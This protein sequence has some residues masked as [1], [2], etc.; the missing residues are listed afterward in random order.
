MTRG[1]DAAR[2]REMNRA[3][4]ERLRG[5]APPPLVAD[6]YELRVLHTTGRASGQQRSTP[7]AVVHHDGRRYLVAPDARRDWVAN[8][9]AHPHGGIEGGAGGD[10]EEIAVTR[11]DGRPAAR[12]VAAYAAATTGPVRAAFPF[13]DDAPIE[14]VEAV[15]DR[16]AVFEVTGAPA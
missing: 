10:V 2:F 4:V 9:D 13:G 5:G 7:L 6:T 16:M 12:V 14:E 11:T 3:M 15:L 8:L 1:A